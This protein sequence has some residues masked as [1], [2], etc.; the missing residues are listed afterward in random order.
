MRKPRDGKARYRCDLPADL[1]LVIAANRFLRRA[2]AQGWMPEPTLEAQ[3]LVSEACR[4]ERV[5]EIPGRAWR[6]P[7]AI[8]LQDL[9]QRARLSPLGRQ[10]ANGQLVTL[11][12]M[13]ARAE[14]LMRRHPEILQRPLRAPVIILGQMRSG[15]TRLHR[16]LAQDPQFAHTRHFESL[17][18]VPHRGRRLRAGAVQLFLEQANPALAA[19]HPTAPLEPEEEFGLHSFSWHGGQFLA[20]WRL[21]AF[22]RYQRR[23]DLTIPYREFAALLR[24][25]G[26]HRGEDADK[27]WLLKS[28]QFMGDLAAVLEQFPDARLLCLE[29][30]PVAVVASSAS[31]VWN[32]RRLHSDASDQAEIG[33]SWLE[34]SVHRGR[35]AEAV[36]R[37]NPQVPQLAIGFDEVTEDWEGAVRRIYAFLDLPLTS[38]VLARMR[39]FMLRPSRHLDH[40][41]ELAEFGLSAAEVRA[42]MRMMEPEG[43]PAPPFMLAPRRARE[44]VSTDNA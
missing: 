25:I 13:R 2:W 43:A 22:A 32:Q 10:I 44:L 17:E 23:R 41:Y 12:R 4:R 3:A 28:P 30:D 24:L 6:E 35:T 38:A 37:A 5:A 39:R 18:P 20:Q 40:R 14:R 7:F 1:P 11:L 26:W 42:A 36:R 19:I 8:L 9:Q 33:R 31:L 27:P 15:T 34:H 29:R 16:L 21:P